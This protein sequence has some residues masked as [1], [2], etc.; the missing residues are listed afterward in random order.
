MSDMDRVSDRDRLERDEQGVIRGE[1]ERGGNKRG[2]NG[3]KRG[4]DGN[5]FRNIILV[6]AILGIV[7]LMVKGL[8]GSK[9]YKGWFRTWSSTNEQG[10]ASIFN[11]VQEL[12]DMNERLGEERGLHDRDRLY[13]DSYIEEMVAK[14]YLVYVFTEDEEK[15]KEFDRWVEENQESVQIFRIAVEDVTTNMEIQSYI[16]EEDEDMPMVLVYNEVARGEKELEG[17]IKDVTLLDETK[18]YI[19]DLIDEKTGQ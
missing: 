18:D 11:S 13:H 14:E 19:N 8:G 5:K 7:F 12:E 17:V 9:D 4:P 6:V 3:N 15:D 10:I 1:Q 16:N 2:S